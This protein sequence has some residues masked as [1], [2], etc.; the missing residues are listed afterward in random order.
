M[1][2]APAAD[3]PAV[4]ASG[5]VHRLFGIGLLLESAAGLAGVPVRDRLQRAVDELDTV[6]RDIRTAVFAEQIRSWVPDRSPGDD[7]MGA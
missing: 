4:A 7:W 1:P 3:E 6:I 5:L 2:L